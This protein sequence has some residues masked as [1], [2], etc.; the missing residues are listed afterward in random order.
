MP[1]PSVFDALL[2][3]A[4]A[5]DRASLVD[6]LRHPEH[7]PSRFDLGVLLSTSGHHRAYVA[8]RVAPD[9]WEATVRAQ[10]PGVG[11]LLDAAPAGG[12]RMVDTDGASFAE[13]Y[14]DDLQES[15]PDLGL[16]CLIWSATTGQLSRVRPVERVPSRFARWSALA[17]LGKL[18]VRTGG[19][20]PHLLWVTE[21]RWS[22]AVAETTRLARAL[23]ALPP[24]WDTV[25]DRVEGAYVDALDIHTDGTVDVTV[26]VLPPPP[27]PQLDGPP[28]RLEP[29]VCPDDR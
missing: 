5:G 15:R 26:G 21:A 23:G 29:G 25:C 22:G 8:D 1:P 2:S 10:L 6:R 3:V 18:A 28:S 27:S 7:D 20:P 4:W 17:S 24:E 9:H 16:M 13:V 11:R 19:G 14:L 12:R